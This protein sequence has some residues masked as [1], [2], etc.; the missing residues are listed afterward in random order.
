MTS[1]P[2]LLYLLCPDYDI[3]NG[4]IIN[5]IRD[6]QHRVWRMRFVHR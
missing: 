4:L 1:L 5:L 6:S 3:N 2:P